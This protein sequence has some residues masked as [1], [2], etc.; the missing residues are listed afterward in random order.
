MQRTSSREVYRN[1]W[2]RV[3][4][5]DVVRPDGS[6][7][8]YGVVEKPDFAVVMP[9]DV[10]D[11]VAGWW[12]VEQHR[13]VI[14]RRVWE[15]PQGTWSGGEGSAAPGSQE[16]LARAE[17]AEETGLRAEHLEHLG[18]LHGAYGYSSQAFD[19]FLATGLTQGEHR[20][21]VTEQDMVHALVPDAEL[22]RMVVDGRVTDGPSLAALQLHDW[23]RAG[24]LG[25]R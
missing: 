3:R 22:P 6:P 16:D 18:R 10:R 12:M 1:A 17:L 23:W 13:Y 2:M 7:G 14:G 4:E 20:R 8:V 25:E 11:G 24:L 19:V 5:D 9:R 21:E 15:F